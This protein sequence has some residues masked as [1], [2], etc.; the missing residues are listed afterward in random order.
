[1]RARETWKRTLAGV[2]Q[3]VD[4]L[5][6]PTMVDEPPLIEDGRSLQTTTLSVTK[7]TYCGAFG[8]LPGLSLPNGMSRNGLP[9]ALQLEA[10]WWQEPLLL[11]AGH[12]FQGVTD[13]HEMR[14]KAVA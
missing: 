6:S 8:Y 14:P 1:M 9:L 5:A 12:A 2:F 13:W 4:I 7:N 3:Q 10:A 11:R